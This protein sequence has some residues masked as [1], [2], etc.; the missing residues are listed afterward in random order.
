MSKIKLQVE[1]NPKVSSDAVV[2]PNGDTIKKGEIV[3]M[4]E[5]D[6]KKVQNIKSNG[7]DLL[8]MCNEPLLLVE[9]DSSDEEE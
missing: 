7:I 5:S 6:W 3:S 9:D 1:I 2:L 4:N 8:V